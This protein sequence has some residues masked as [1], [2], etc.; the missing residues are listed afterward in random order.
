MKNWWIYKRERQRNNILNNKIEKTFACKGDFSIV[1]AG[2]KRIYLKSG[3]IIEKIK[4][5]KF[6]CILLKNFEDIIQIQ[7][8]F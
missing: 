8:Y 6:A 4:S 7:K 5:F 3:C 1:F 2:K